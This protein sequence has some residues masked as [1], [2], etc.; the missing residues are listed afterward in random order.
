MNKK[1]IKTLA[2]VACGLGV[3]SSIPFIA[4]SCNKNNDDVIP[5]SGKII[6]TS[7]DYNW[8]Q[9]EQDGVT[10][11]IIAGFSNSGLKKLETYKD[12]DVKQIEIYQRTDKDV[13]ALNNIA[14]LPSWITEV[15]IPE[16]IQ[17]CSSYYGSDAY[18]PIFPSHIQKLTFKSSLVQI[19]GASTA[20]GFGNLTE[21]SCLYLENIQTIN[22]FFNDPVD[23]GKNAEN[24]TVYLPANLK[25]ETFDNI[26]NQLTA[27][28]KN[29]TWSYE[30]IRQ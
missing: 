16:K 17:I 9:K 20:T 29:V 4:S 13:E 25:Q 2:S 24:P 6:T 30:R 1:L 7:D 28:F 8:I 12:S 21:L 10:K 15:I 18:A 14:N 11:N 27:H 3:V 26:K 19:E 5:D 23:C 22:I